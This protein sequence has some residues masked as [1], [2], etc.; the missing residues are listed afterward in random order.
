MTILAAGLLYAGPALADSD[1][2]DFEMCDG[3]AA[4]GKQAD[5]MRAPSATSLWRVAE[6][7]DGAAIAACTRALAS[8]R[9]LPTQ[10]LRRV[11][12]LRARAAANIRVGELPAALVDHDAAEGA[13]APLASDLFYKRSMGVSLTLLRALALARRGD[14]TGAAPLARAAMAARPYALQVQM[15]G[16]TV[17]AQLP[18]EG[19]AAMDGLIRLQ[20]DLSTRLVTLELN[21]GHFQKVLALAPQA[22]ASWPTSRL[23][24]MAL[25][26][27]AP[28]AMALLRA[29]ALTSQT[30]YARAAT[31]DAAGA[32]SDLAKAGE[33]LDTLLPEPPAD[34]KTATGTA[35]G[36]AYLRVLN[37]RVRR[38][39]TDYGK[40]V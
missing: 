8:S 29:L 27:Q 7:H 16:A 39:A 32:R 38:I 14:A 2:V 31:G 10:T 11:H 37:D 40:L 26:V 4:P 34:S 3:L 22:Q 25:A 20:P 9:L 17:L 35:D 15:V 19:A 30:A 24:T 36:S 28:D 33:E 5:G 21:A 12:L 23:A 18:D 6:D 1:K 13:G